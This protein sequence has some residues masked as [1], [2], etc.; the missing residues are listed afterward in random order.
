[1]FNGL[2]DRN[3]NFYMI[4]SRNLLQIP[5]M[6]KHFREIATRGPAVVI[7]LLPFLNIMLVSFPI[8]KDNR[9]RNKPRIRRTHNPQPQLSGLARDDIALLVNLK[10]YFKRFVPPSG[11]RM[12]S[13]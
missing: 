10:N 7:V 6:R 5:P 12:S 13:G 11:R 2:L 8:R 3:K 1:M 4:R 9:I